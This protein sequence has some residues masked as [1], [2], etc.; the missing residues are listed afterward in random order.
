MLYT[1]N[2]SYNS[3][4][5]QF[6]YQKK[7]VQT[8]LNYTYSKSMG[9]STNSGQ[10]FRTEVS[11]TQNSYCI[12]CEHGVLNFDRTH[13]FTGNV[14]YALSVSGIAIAQSGF[15]LTPTMANPNSGLTS[16]PDQVGAI[17]KSGDRNHIFNA[18]AFAVP[19]YGFF[20]TASNG[21]LRGP[22]DVAF[23]TAIYKT[24]AFTDRVNFQFRAE[25]FNIANHPDFQ[26]ANTGI[27][28]N[29]PNPGLV[30]SPG[31]QRILEMVGRITF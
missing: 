2:S 11:S 25:A 15:A 3:L 22:K 29:E 16:R 6:K 27:G 13:M 4:Q 8:T 20:G 19:G 17:H 1:G 23:N 31:D 24:Y 7:V 5:S 30:N 26:N 18:N 28:S 9:D 12:K 21:S 10:D 14:I